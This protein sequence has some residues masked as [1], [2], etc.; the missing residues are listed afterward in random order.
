MACDFVIR[1]RT[2]QPVRKL[3]PGVLNGP[4]LFMVI[5]WHPVIL[6]DDVDDHPPDAPGNK[7]LEFVIPFRVIP[8]DSLHDGNCALV[9]DILHLHEIRIQVM[10]LDCNCLGYV[11]IPERKLL[12]Y[13][14]LP[15]PVIHGQQL[16]IC[17]FLQSIQLPHIKS[18]FTVSHPAAPVPPTSGCRLTVSGHY[19]PL[20]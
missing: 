15:V 10:H 20:H 8:L 2:P 18:S 3:C 19:L 12:L 11:E 7:C 4:V 14:Q 16:F 6:A 13:F 17:L 1:G 5:P 9:D